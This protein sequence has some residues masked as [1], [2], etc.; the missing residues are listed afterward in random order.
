MYNLICAILIILITLIIVIVVGG[1]EKN[2]IVCNRLHDE[3][4]Q[5]P[6]KQRMYY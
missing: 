3:L 1:D 6:R 4:K 5:K 2:L